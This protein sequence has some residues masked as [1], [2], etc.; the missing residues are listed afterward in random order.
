[1]MEIAFGVQVLTSRWHCPDVV[2]CVTPALLAT[3]MAVART[4]LSRRRPATGVLVQDIYSRGIEETGAASGLTARALRALESWTVRRA[5][6]V[7]VI[8]D[9][10]HL[11]MTTQLGVAPERARVIRN[12]THIDAPDP[13]AS[14]AFRALYGWR[15]DEVVVLHA[16]N[17]GYKQGLENVVAAGVLAAQQDVAVRFVLMGDG[18]QREA[19]QSE[20][21]GVTAVQFIPPV[22]DEEFSAALGAADVLLVN[23]RPGIAQMSVPSK[24]TSYFRSGKPILAAVD[25]AGLAA[26]EVLAAEAGVCVPADRPDLLVAEALRLGSDAGLAEK[27]GEA[28]RRYSGELLSEQRA[29]ESYENWVIDL[30]CGRTVAEEVR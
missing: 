18:N 19:L 9:G 12:W 26:Q 13:S 29:L 6:G 20:A 28:G 3:A 5:D 16:G 2:I 7:S 4:R 27:L 22:S 25:G 8:H 1:M 10:F 30:D 15:S 21:D 14:A 11:D 23:E 17:M 24:L